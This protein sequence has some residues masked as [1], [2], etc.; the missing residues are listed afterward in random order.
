[1]RV[2]KL[3]E[4]SIDIEFIDQLVFLL[5]LILPPPAPQDGHLRERID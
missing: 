3:T 2:L 5:R 4:N 1:M